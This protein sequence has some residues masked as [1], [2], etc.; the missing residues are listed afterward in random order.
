[1]RFTGWPPEAITWFEGLEADNS[2][3]W[4]HAHRDVYDR[5]VRGPLEALLAEVA[6]EFGEGSAF[7]PNRDTRFSADK[8]PYKT[9]AAAAI[10]RPAG[11]SYYVQVSADGLLS[12]VGWYPF[13]RDQLERF[14]RGVAGDTEGPR[15]E[16]I[17]GDL[18]ANGFNVDGHD[19]LK[20]AP[21]GYP[22][23]H[24]RVEFL[25][26]KDLLVGIDHPPRKWLATRQALTRVVAPWRAA[27]PMLDW[28]DRVVGPSAEG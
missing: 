19:S 27:A 23:D 26:L 21:R 8:S 17:V 12:G 22:K 14:R 20:S 24:P 10:R 5:A 1:V 18:R 4:F 25:R 28:M 6:P 9:A 11:G 15:F 2:K 16:T 13:A 3:A 7:R